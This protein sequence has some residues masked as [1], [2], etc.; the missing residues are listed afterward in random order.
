MD[1]DSLEYV[2]LTEVEKELQAKIQHGEAM[3]AEA[4]RLEEAERIDREQLD[5]FRGSQ[6]NMPEACE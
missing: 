3:R 2:G 1:P 6:T 5:T 4:K